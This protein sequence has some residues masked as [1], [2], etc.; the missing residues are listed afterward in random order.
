M[1]TTLNS[2]G[3]PDPYEVSITSKMLGTTKRSANGTIMT[4]Y[5]TTILQKDIKVNWR[6]I[7]STDR[8]LILAGCENA[9]TTARALVLPGYSSMQV[10]FPSDSAVVQTEVRSSGTWL[11]NLDVTFFE[12][13]RTT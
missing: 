8:D 3:L 2:V 4:D 6:L 1:T 13:L 5:V 10:L 7:N 11:Y 12:N 9:I